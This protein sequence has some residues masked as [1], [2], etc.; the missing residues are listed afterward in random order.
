M[1]DAIAR[2]QYDYWYDNAYGAFPLGK[3]WATATEWERD[4]ARK[5][6]E[7]GLTGLVSTMK[8]YESTMPDVAT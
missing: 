7:A 8:R 3:T 5:M 6:A 1:I 2:A 4:F